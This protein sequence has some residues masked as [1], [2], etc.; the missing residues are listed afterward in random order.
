[1]NSHI[2]RSSPCI[3]IV[4]VT[5]HP[6]M[7]QLALRLN[8]LGTEVCI[9]VVDNTPCRADG[10]D[11]FQLTTSL[12]TLFCQPNIA[13]LPMH[14]N[15]GIA[16]AQNE[17]IRWLMERQCSHVVFFDQDSLY[18]LEYVQAI[19]A[20]Y[21][22][23]SQLHPQLGILG[24]RVYNLAN[25]EEYRSAVHTDVPSADGFVP[26]R[27]IISSGSCLSMDKLRSIGMM[28]EVL[29]IDY[30]DFEY[31]WRAAGKGLV[32][33]ITTAVQLNHKVGRRDLRLPHGY[34]VIISAPFR[35]F[36]QYRNHL[37]LCRRGYVPLQWK[38]NTGVK[39]LLRIIYFPFV[40]KGWMLIERY[41][42]KGVYHGIFKSAG[43]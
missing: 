38:V 36:Y 28:D 37:W 22:R 6:D 35:Y 42:L 10:R 21:I 41:M 30:V 11:A 19:V 24:P 15:T 27:D 4:I 43:Q 18:T 8:A 23:I 34:R 1:M 25:G 7:N 26:R 9:A 12:Q 16:C 33:G 5:Y 20:E 3:G 2:D 31:S 40:V 32:C 39:H 13:Y 17:G 14:C 29:F